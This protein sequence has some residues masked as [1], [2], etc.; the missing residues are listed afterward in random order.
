MLHTV[1]TLFFGSSDQLSIDHEGCRR[2]TVEGV[3]PQDGGHVAGDASRSTV[4]DS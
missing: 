4:S 2:V 1:E 3:E